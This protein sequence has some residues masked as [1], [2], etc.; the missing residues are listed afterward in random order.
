MKAVFFVL[1]TSILATRGGEAADTRCEAAET[2]CD[3]TQ[4]NMKKKQIKFGTGE[5][6]RKYNMTFYKSIA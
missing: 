5:F 2:F 3:Y 1:D 4:G 6:G